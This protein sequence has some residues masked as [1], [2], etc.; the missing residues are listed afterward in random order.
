MNQRI[1]TTADPRET[2]K[3]Y[4]QPASKRSCWTGWWRKSCTTTLRRNL[5]CTNPSNETT[6]GKKTHS[7][8]SSSLCMLGLTVCPTLEWIKRLVILSSLQQ[9]Q[10]ASRRRHQLAIRFLRKAVSRTWA[11]Q[12]ICT[13][14]KAKPSSTHSLQASI[15]MMLRGKLI[16]RRWSTKLSMASVTA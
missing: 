4:S 11:C 16:S 9:S 8:S 14:I 2:S 15:L 13:L 10:V 7:H 6:A 5:C 3:T 1:F 12:T